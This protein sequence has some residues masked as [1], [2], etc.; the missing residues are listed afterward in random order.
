MWMVSNGYHNTQTRGKGPKIAEIQAKSSYGFEVMSKKILKSSIALYI[1][2]PPKGTL[3]HAY[4]TS[5]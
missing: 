2:T 5:T 1:R 4:H 3:K